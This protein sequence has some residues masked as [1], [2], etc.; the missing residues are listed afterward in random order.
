MMDHRYYTALICENGHVRSYMR[1]VEPQLEIRRCPECGAAVLDQCPSCAAPLK[2]CDSRQQQVS[3]APIRYEYVPDV[4]KPVRAAYCP[5]C[6]CA[7]PWTKAALDAAQE[8]IGETED[9][10]C[11]EKEKLKASLPD[12][13]ADTPQ[14]QVAVVRVKKWL[15]MAGK[16]IGDAYEGG[17]QCSH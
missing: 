8:L 9:L 16:P 15:G 12:L 7:Y 14:T 3:Y 13:I 17:C 10:S 1:E 6:G 2:G 4:R 11:E 5:H